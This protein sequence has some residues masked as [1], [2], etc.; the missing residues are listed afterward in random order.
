MLTGLGGRQ[1]GS[2]RQ[3]KKRTEKNRKEQKK[4][5]EQKEKINFGG[6]LGKVGGGKNRKGGA[7]AGGDKVGGTTL[8]RGSPKNKI[9]CV[10]SSEV[11][12]LSLL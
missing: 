3:K 9:K 6:K 10:L 7:T 5:K 1:Q 11:R 8:V 12:N 2:S 4:Q